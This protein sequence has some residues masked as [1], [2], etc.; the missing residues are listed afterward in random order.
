MA[1]R[2]IEV[3]GLASGSVGSQKASPRAANLR[4]LKRLTYVAGD[5]LALTVA[6]MAAVRLVRHFLEIPLSVQNPSQYHRYYIPLF[7]AVLYLVEG[8]KSQGLRRPERE[9]ELGCKA[10]LAA[11]AGLM[12]LNFLLFK[13]QVISRYLMVTWAAISCVSLVVAR[14]ILRFA[15]SRLWKAGMARRT[16]ILIGSLSGMSGFQQLLSIQRYNGYKLLGLI[17]EDDT[18]CHNSAGMGD[19]AV[20][21]FV[22]DWQRV[23][24]S[25]RP[26]VLIM[27]LS[28]AD[29]DDQILQTVLD[30]SK[31]L[32]VELELYSKVLAA[33][34][35][36]CERDEFSG[37][38]RFYSRPSW[39]IAM[40]RVTKRIL[41][42][43]IG[44]VGTVVTLGLIPVIG[45]LIKL[46]DGGPIFYRSAY[47]DP[48]RRNRYYLKFRTM[49]VDADQ[50]LEQ[51]AKLRS[52]FSE[53]HKLEEDPRVTPV[54]RFL[55]KTSLDE[56]PQFFSLLKGDLS[57]VGPRTIRR[58]EGYRYGASLPRLLSVKPGMTGF[59]QVMG[60]QTTTYEERVQMDLFYIEHWS[61][62][63]DLFLIGKTFWKVFKCEGAY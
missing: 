28:A 56:F 26:D 12:A 53:R 33:S 16:A 5:V 29:N 40:Q 35:L 30:R 44:V 42:F 8:Y 3:L 52:E 4:I 24:E 15:Y 21:G 48:D 34:E 25:H 1:D 47:V 7:A 58:E 11:F 60:R 51:D 62:W 32:G 20:L 38:L 37:C 6:H 59:W 22:N 19:L 39:A 9:L 46:Q 63:L 43:I 45:L 50:V 36:N 10:V 49:R 14:S 31:E 18:D 41:D 17:S 2:E 57:F 54:G 27:A 13:D 61:I 23:V 55:R